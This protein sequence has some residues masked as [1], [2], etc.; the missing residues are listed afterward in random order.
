M[1]P[2]STPSDDYIIPSTAGPDTCVGTGPFTLQTFE[3]YEI[4]YQVYEDYYL[5]RSE[6]DE[7]IFVKISDDKKGKSKVLLIT[8]GV[9]KDLPNVYRAGK[10]IKNVDILSA[11]LLNTYE[12]LKHKNLLI[13]KE[14]VEVLR[15][16][17]AKQS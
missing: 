4:R 10:N 8:S 9:P 6:I 2:Y 7:L 1:S 14:S 17:S 13:M 12:V 16:G 3:N 11:N 15:G 5:G